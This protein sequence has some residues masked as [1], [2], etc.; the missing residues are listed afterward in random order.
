MADVFEEAAAASCGSSV[1]RCGCITWPQERRAPTARSTISSPVRSAHQA[2]EVLVDE[3]VVLT[4]RHAGG[5]QRAGRSAQSG[6]PSALAQAHPLLVGGDGQRQP[7]S[8]ADR[9]R[10]SRWCGTGSAA[11][12]SDRGSRRA[13]TAHRT[14]EY[15]ITCSAATLSAAS[16]I[17]ASMMHALAGAAAML[18]REQQRVEACTPGVRVADRVRLVGI[19]VGIAGQPADPGRRLDDVGERGVVPPRSVEARSRASAA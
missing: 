3:I 18:Q 14:P 8:R 2:A 7:S 17:A 10:R 4:P 1:W 12:P 5:R 13:A 11:P 16:T 9:T 19:A 6:R 15:S